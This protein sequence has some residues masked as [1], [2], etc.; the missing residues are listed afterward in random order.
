VFSAFSS[1]ILATDLSQPVTST[2]IWRLLGTNS[3]LAISCSCQFRRLDP[4]LYCSV[5]LQLLNSEFQFSNLISLAQ[6]KVKVKVMLRPTVSRPVCL[7]IKHPSRAYDQIFI[8]VRQLQVCLC[9]APSLTRGRVCRLPESLISL[10]KI[11]VTLRLT[12][13]QSVSLGVEPYL[14]LMTRY[15]L[16]FDSYGPVFVGRPLWREDGSVFCICCWPLQA[17]SFSGPSPL[18]LAT[19]F[20]FLRFETSLFVSSYDSQGHGGGIRPRL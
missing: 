4:I 5:L 15:L 17:Q 3:Y 7:E 12:V 19:I 13:S 8:T 6:D 2:H 18:G 16:L 20:Y 1:R 9:G 14:G 11:K 10:A